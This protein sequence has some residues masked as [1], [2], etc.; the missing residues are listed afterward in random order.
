MSHPIQPGVSRYNWD[1][2]PDYDK[3]SLA[4]SEILDIAFIDMSPLYFRPD[5]HPPKHI[6]DCL[7]Y[8]IPGPLDIFPQLLLNMLYN[9]EL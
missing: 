1:Y 4:Y 5:S 7:H 6:D 3:F 8:C 2:F 9:K